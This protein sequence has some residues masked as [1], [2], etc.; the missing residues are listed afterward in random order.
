MKRPWIVDA[1]FVPRSDLVRNNG[2]FLERNPTQQPVHLLGGGRICQSFVCNRT[3][4]FMSKRTVR[5]C[6]D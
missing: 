2:G 1:S 3:D 5:L 6:C 4:D